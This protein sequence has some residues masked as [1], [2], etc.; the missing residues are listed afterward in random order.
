MEKIFWFCILVVRPLR[1]VGGGLSCRANDFFAASLNSFQVKC[2]T[3]DIMNNENNNYLTPLLRM[4]V[5]TA[6]IT[7]LFL[8]KKLA[9][10]VNKGDPDPFHDLS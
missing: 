10:V 4:R 5:L 1:G 6:S 2:A 8:K 3:N 7:A 9:N